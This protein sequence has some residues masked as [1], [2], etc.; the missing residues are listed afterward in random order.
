[1]GP[2]AGGAGGMLAG[3]VGENAGLNLSSKQI[4]RSRP[5]HKLG[6]PDGESSLVLGG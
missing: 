6:I 3:F 2:A 4:D 1:V 5:V